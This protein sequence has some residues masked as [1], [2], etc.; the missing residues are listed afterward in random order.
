MSAVHQKTSSS[1]RSNTH[2]LESLAPSR[3]PALEC[4][5]PLGLP[6]EPEVYSRN[7]GCSALSHTGSQTGLCP[8][9]TSCHHRSWPSFLVTTWPVRFSATILPMLLQR[10]ESALSAVSL[11]SMFLP[12]QQPPSAV[13]RTVAPASSM[14]SLSDMAENP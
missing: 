5:M 3:K 1:L 14:R 12:A 6:V 9:M 11:R 8:S 13:T 2:L 4:W 10:C 7:N